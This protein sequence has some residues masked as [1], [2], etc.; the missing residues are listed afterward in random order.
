MRHSTF[1]PYLP[2]IY[3]CAE[4]GNGG[5]VPA[6]WRKTDV[7]KRVVLNRGRVKS[8]CGELG[9]VQYRRVLY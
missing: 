9:A 2:E 4:T 6:L 1:L 8:V 5:A 7:T 3:S